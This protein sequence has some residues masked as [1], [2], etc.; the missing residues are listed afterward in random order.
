MSQ[1]LPTGGFKGVEKPDKLKGQISNL[2]KN[3]SK[4]YL[5]EVDV[6]Y[7]DNL[8]DLHNDRPFMCEKRKINGVQKLV[9]NLF[10]EKKYVIHIVALDQALKY[11]LIL[12]SI[13]QA[14]EFDQ[15]AWLGQYIDFNT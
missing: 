11:S 2:A 1:P 9:P 7:R 13:H 5:L 6:S 12:K 3:H 15:S 10:H 8:R 14:I 4:G